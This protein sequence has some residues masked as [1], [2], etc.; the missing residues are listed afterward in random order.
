MEE[1]YSA[2]G[3]RQANVTFGKASSI[4]MKLRVRVCKQTSKVD[5]LGPESTVGELMEHIR[6]VLLPG[7]GLGPDVT[8]ALSLDGA[9]LLADTG[10]KLSSCGV[11]P[12]DLVRVLLPAADGG[13]DAGSRAVP[14][15]RARP[16]DD[17]TGARTAPVMTP[18]QP[19]GGAPAE[20]ETLGRE[21]TLC[22][23]AGE[24]QAPRSLELL[25]RAADPTCPA[26]A[27]VVAA[28]LL[29]LETGFAPQSHEAEPAEMPPGWRSSGGAYR[30]Q[31][32]H[33][34][35]ERATVTVV[36]VP[37]SPVLVIQAILQ[38]ADSAS[39]A[40]KVCV[41]PAGY[42]TEAWPGTS[43]AAAYTGLSRLSR[44]FKDQLVYPLI[45]ATREGKARPPPFGRYGFPIHADPKTTGANWTPPRE[46]AV[47]RSRRD[48]FLLRSGRNFCKKSSAGGG[49]FDA[50]RP[51][52]CRPAL[53]LPAAFGLSALPPEL[54][55]LVLR[56]L[57]VV[58]VV[59]LSAVCRHLNA[60]AADA[61]LWRHLVRRDFSDHKWQGETNWK[62][63]YKS[64]Y[65]FRHK[66]GCAERPC[67]LPPFIHRPV[68]GPA[69]YPPVPGILGGGY[70]RRPPALPAPRYDP[71]GPLTHGERRRRSDPRPPA[72]GGA[73]P[74]D[75]RRGFI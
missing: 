31:Y 53:R 35:C 48:N 62:E 75:V 17:R 69:P 46:G 23:E 34:L 42:V 45:A 61:A 33:A 70:D 2:A 58:S 11:V 24:G 43:A 60:A 28:H 54:L 56:L 20:P 32:T 27:V 12:G 41:D 65:K 55:L 13:P 30:L 19:R 68:F 40:A 5:A 71:V 22:G 14:A 73:R 6:H 16:G 10:Q 8:F 52:F 3:G 21:P 37:M 47:I 1:E 57:D 18:S 74:G 72:G 63:L 38:L 4:R 29:M 39:M 49:G 36:A 9:E 44:V 26:D 64:F 7:H 25:Y 50:W 51:C 66:R 59:R 15:D 67:S